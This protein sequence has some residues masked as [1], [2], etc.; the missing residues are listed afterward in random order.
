VTPSGRIRREDDGVSQRR[1]GRFS[2]RRLRVVLPALLVLV[3]I[4][5]VRHG[6]N[7]HTPATAVPGTKIHV[8]ATDLRLGDYSL[9]LYGRDGTPS[10][11]FCQARI[12]GVNYPQSAIDFTARLPL[13]LPCFSLAT[14]APA[15]SA[16]VTPG[17]YALIISVPRG[18]GFDSRHSYISRRIR[19]T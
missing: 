19:I 10:P 11:R 13:R 2:D 16:L 8:T 9:A 3:A 5:L 6:P 4:V 17:L 12:A 7:V 1:S 14:A 15:G 18:T